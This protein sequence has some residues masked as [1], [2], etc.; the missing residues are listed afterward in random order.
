MITYEEAIKVLS[1]LQESA[2]YVREHDN[3]VS[4]DCFHHG[5]VEDEKRIIINTLATLDLE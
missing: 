1:E 2:R 4:M 5:C 3:Y